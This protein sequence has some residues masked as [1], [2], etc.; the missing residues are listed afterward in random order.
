MMNTA[1][2]FFAVSLMVLL[3]AILYGRNMSS[4]SSIPMG[5][6]LLIVMVKN[7]ERVIL[8]LLSSAR[9]VATHLLICDT[10]STDNTTTI[11]FNAPGWREMRRYDAGP[12]VNFEHNRNKCGVEA[13]RL[14]KE[15]WSSVQW[16]LLADADFELHIRPPIVPP[17]YDVN[18]IQLHSAHPGH[19]HNALQLLIRSK[20][21]GFCI[22][23]L[24]T[25]EFIDCSRDVN[26]TQGHY[27]GLYYVDHIDG[28]SRPDK[29]VRDIA[30]LSQWL[31]EQHEKQ[32]MLVPRALYYLARAY[33]DNNQTDKALVAYAEH[34]KV[35]TYTNYRFYAAYRKALIRMAL[36][37]NNV[38]AVSEAFM[39]SVREYDGYFRAEPLY[40]LA[41]FHRT[42]GDLSL[43][44]IYATAAL[45]LPPMR[46]DRIPLFLET[47][48][49]EYAAREE[50]GW[51]LLLKDDKREAA[52]HF[53]TILA[54]PNLALDVRERVE[55]ERVECS[56]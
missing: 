1:R 26:A 7:E 47:Y 46:H 14:L 35:E 30:L 55:R 45:N 10:G 9:K 29:L 51:C 23:R 56:K 13:Y 18:T 16:I 44:V 40:H 48:V 19:P 15:D 21:F 49:Y 2:L 54:I 43:C 4:P 41:R 25:H 37:P 39:E 52:R 11:A 32:P 31:A 36:E 22:Y 20:T 28:K 5:D 3:C 53:D 12:F 33:E 24:W 38:H 27:N 8:R 17:V 34:G 42:H 50:L 6:T